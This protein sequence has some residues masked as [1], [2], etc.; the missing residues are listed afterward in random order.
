MGVNL[1]FAYIEKRREKTQRFNT[2]G[3]FHIPDHNYAINANS[4]K[5]ILIPYFNHVLL[6]DFYYRFWTWNNA[7]S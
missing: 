3:L 4:T 2:F 7:N 5:K 1:V 6:S